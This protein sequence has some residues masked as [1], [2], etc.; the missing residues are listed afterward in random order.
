MIVAGTW[1]GA[2]ALPRWCRRCGRDGDRD[3]RLAAIV[4]AAAS[5]GV[6]EG[7]FG[8][9]APE[10]GA[11]GWFAR[12]RREDQGLAQHPLGGLECVLIAVVTVH[13]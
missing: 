5:P 8:G 2:P 13:R 1:H 9:Q 4:Q 10:I 12:P 11:R 7:V 3:E 6:V